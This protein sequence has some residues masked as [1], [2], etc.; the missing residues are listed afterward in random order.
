[1]VSG[2]WLRTFAIPIVEDLDDAIRQQNIAR[3]H[4]TMDDA[5]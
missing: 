2:S 5:G 3:F 4:V 1:V